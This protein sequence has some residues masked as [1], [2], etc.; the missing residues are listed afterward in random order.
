MPRSWPRPVVA[1]WVL[2]VLPAVVHVLYPDGVVAELAYYGASLPPLVAW[3]GVARAPRGGCRVV[4]RAFRGD[5]H[6]LDLLPAPRAFP[7]EDD[8]DGAGRGGEAGTRAS[9]SH[10]S[11]KAIQS[12]ERY[13]PAQKSRHRRYAAGARHP[14]CDSG[15]LG[16]HPAS[17]MMFSRS[18]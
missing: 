11:P 13:H 17:G 4:G 16:L 3:I 2:A 1:L 7:A 14:A 8:L 6:L 10:G 15:A 5:L 9:G 18:S 12:G